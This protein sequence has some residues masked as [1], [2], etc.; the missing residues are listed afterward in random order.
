MI[1]QQ[2][3]NLPN[4]KGMIKVMPNMPGMA[5]NPLD[6]LQSTASKLKSTNESYMKQRLAQQQGVDQQQQQMAKQSLDEMYAMGFADKCAELN[7]DPGALL[8][9]AK[10]DKV[11][12][13]T[14][15]GAGIGGKLGLMA[16]SAAGIPAVRKADAA[17][18]S[19]RTLTEFLNRVKPG[20]EAAGKFRMPFFRFP[21]TRALLPYSVVGGT[22]G[23]ASG[24]LAG[25]RVGQYQKEQSSIKHRL[26]KLVGIH[27]T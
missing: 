23:L 1:Q 4:D 25:R 11:T 13:D 2:V 21:R 20:A 10:T 9:V 12:R 6:A 15:I 22:L 18:R 26:S 19:L 5:K 3:Q 24:A 8:K 16:G 14:V 7:T 27:N 17:N